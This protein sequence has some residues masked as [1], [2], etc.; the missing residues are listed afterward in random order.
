M[1]ING[2]LGCFNPYFANQRKM[3]QKPAEEEPKLKD[4]KPQGNESTQP[5][6]EKT[7]HNY[8]D[9]KGN[10]YFLTSSDYEWG[11]K[12]QITHYPNGT[13]CVFYY[14][15]NGRAIKQELYKNGSTEPYVSWNL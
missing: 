10:H 4:V 5:K 1:N 11:D 3:T 15:D 6:R 2:R 8:S 14:D 7:I 9:G 12:R 13:A